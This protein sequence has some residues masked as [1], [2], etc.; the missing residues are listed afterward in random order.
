MNGV[1]DPME[2]CRAG[3]RDAWAQAYRENAPRV[4]V[5]LRRLQVPERDVE[6]LVQQVFA[7]LFTTLDRYRGE[8][9]LSTWLYGIAAHQASR[10]RR[11]EFRWFRRRDALARELAGFVPGSEDPA[12]A[13]WARTALRTLAVALDDLPMPLRTVWV[14][15]EWEG[16]DTD[17]V[18]C[19]LGLPAGTVRS[20]LCRAR[21]A[22]LEALRQAG[23]E[24]AMPVETWGRTAIG[25]LPL[26]EG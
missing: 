21:G 15:R 4:A 20:R 25:G 18:G 1:G 7:T 2:R 11:L 6:D 8:G 16:L 19:A 26:D 5:F 3:D 17:E 23:F 14:L 13:V 9:Q 22:V 24:E 12:R 10:R